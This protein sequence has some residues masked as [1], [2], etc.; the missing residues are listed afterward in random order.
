MKILKRE[1]PLPEGF[2][3]VVGPLAEACE[4]AGIPCLM[5]PAPDGGTTEWDPAFRFFAPA[6]GVEL[7]LTWPKGAE[8]PMK[9]VIAE[10]L[11]RGDTTLP[12]AA[13]SIYRLGGLEALAAFLQGSR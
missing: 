2:I 7:L 3:A 11:R 6:W 9:R 4:S 8:G 13:H 5:K 10:T 12:V 1:A